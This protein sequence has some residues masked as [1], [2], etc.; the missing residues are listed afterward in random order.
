MKRFGRL[1]L[2]LLFIVSG[3]AGTASAQSAH[4]PWAIQA[5]AAATFGRSSSSSFGGE[6][7]RRLGGQLDLT[8]EGG[9]M[10]NITSRGT[11]DRAS[12]LAASINATSNPVQSAIYYDLGLRYRLMPDGKWNPY[13]AVAFGGARIKTATTFSINGAELTGDQLIA[14]RVALGA[15]L[16][17]TIMKPFLVAAVGVSLPIGSRYFLDGS[18]R[19]GRVFPRTSEIDGDKANS[20]LR[21]QVGFGLRF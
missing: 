4:T 11:Q 5:D 15:D 7:D 14:N 1:M 8:L 16:D 20:T 6:V 19:Y 2:G 18:F 17:G 13:V 3:F 21:L 10:G 9:R 12:I